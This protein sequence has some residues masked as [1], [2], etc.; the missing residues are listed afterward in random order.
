MKLVGNP[1]GSYTLLVPQSRIPQNDEARSSSVPLTLLPT[2]WEGSA[3][4]A[5]PGASDQVF[6]PALTRA[7]IV[8]AGTA[9]LRRWETFKASSYAYYHRW[10]ARL[11]PYVGGNGDSILARD[12]SF[13]PATIC[14]HPLCTIGSQWFTGYPHDGSFTIRS[15]DSDQVY[16]TG[17][18]FVRYSDPTGSLNGKITLREY[19]LL[20]TKNYRGRWLV[21]RV[22]ADSIR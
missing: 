22:V 14:P 20:F 17:Y 19:A 3:S 18:G 8:A 21:T 16:L 5:A 4:Q 10:E 15:Y 13:A 9:F 2:H 6:V 12:E 7:H 11:S 1:N